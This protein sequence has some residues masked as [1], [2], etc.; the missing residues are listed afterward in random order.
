MLIMKSRLKHVLQILVASLFA[1]SATAATDDYVDRTF[2]VTGTWDGSRLVASRV[3]LRVPAENARRAQVSGAIGEVSTGRDSFTVGPIKVFITRETRLERI[4]T[5]QL[6]SSA[7]VRVSG[8]MRADGLLATSIRPQTDMDPGTVQLTGVVTAREERSDGSRELVLGGINVHMMR[9]G[10]NGIDSLVRRQDSRRPERFA[11]AT[12][13]G[14]P[15][16]YSAELQTDVRGR[17]NYELQQSDRVV[18]SETELSAD[19]FYQPAERIFVYAGAKALYQADL[20]REDGE[21]PG[22]G[23]LERDQSWIYFDRLGGSGFGL[24][25]GRQNFKETRSW[26]WDDDLDA[27]R[28]YY[29]R[30]PY[31]VEFGVARELA[32]VS[33]LDRGIDPEQQGVTRMMGTASWLWAPGQ[34]LQLFAMQASDGSG[35]GRVGQVLDPADEDD[36]DADLAWIGLRAMGSHAFDSAGELQYWIDTATVRG[37]EAQVSYRDTGATS[38]VS[39]VR[40]VSVRGSA[41]DLGLSWQL[42]VGAGPSITIGYATSTGDRSLA[43]GVDNAFRQTG[44]HENKW[45]FGGVNRFRNYGEVLRPELSNLEISTVSLGWPLLVNSSLELS[46]HGYRQAVARNQ[47]RDARVDGDLTGTSTDIGEELDLILGFREGRRMDLAITGGLFR[48]GD[49][50]GRRK[51]ELASILNVGLRL[52]F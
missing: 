49:A 11:Q 25:L 52:R 19:V 1:L 48:A 37:D 35:R 20:H 21:E 9:P 22:A 26:W 13:F 34:T 17:D 41:I 24:Q 7:M 31:H 43:D 50:Y 38:T 33:S 10:F 16:G 45:R 27:A 32:R 51:G 18:D 8:T 36:S 15:F 14:R 47:L 44:L 6:V 40:Q 3:Q 42:P 4:T 5:E 23:S 29:D 46:Y 12:L 30:G 39:G 2:R 28:L